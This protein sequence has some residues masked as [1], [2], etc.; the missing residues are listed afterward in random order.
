MRVSATPERRTELLEKLL[1]VTARLAE[2]PDPIKLMERILDEGIAIVR[3]ERGF[4]VA[5]FRAADG[6]LTFRVVAA[7]NVEKAA[8]EKPDF[9]FSRTVVRKVA[10]AG[11]AQLVTDAP[12]DPLTKDVTSI[13]VIDVR[14]VICAPL[15]AQGQTLGVLYLDHR[16]VKR[17]FTAGDLAAVETFARPAAV[18]LAAAQR[19]EQIAAQRDEL[20]KRV[21]IIERLR[22][23]LKEQYL[24]RSRELNQLREQAPAAPGSE[25]GVPEIVA[26]SPAMKAV[27]QLVRRVAPADASVLIVG[28]SGTGKEGLARA[29]HSRSPRARGPFRAE[30]CAAIPDTLLESELFGHER[31]AFTGAE[32]ARVGIF[33][34]ARGGTILLDEIGDMSPSLQVKLLRVLQERAIRRVGGDELIPVDVRIIGATHHDLEAMVA[35]GRFRADL[36]YRLNVVRIEVPP[37]RERLA[38]IPALIDHFLA[39]FRDQNLVVEPQVRELLLTYP[40]PGNVRELQN[41]VRRLAVLAGQGGTVR[42]GLL[43]ASILAHAGRG[44]REANKGAAAEPLLPAMWR[45]DDV[46][47][48]AIL[49]A[50]RH[51][52]G[53]KTS[54]AKLLGVPKTTLYHRMEK[55]EI[56]S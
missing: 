53:N 45:L 50:L 37:L 24:E 38:C 21:A 47:R 40:W 5:S 8:I 46:E 35:D 54:A 44:P 15:R 33:E 29:L 32:S 25:P 26:R 43:S 12:N 55:L 20:A 36:Y 30:N 9:E 51:C 1:E 27:L 39:A 34:A 16:F 4:A 41:E 22:A 31:G 7:R 28:E 49:R 11:V 2:E 6:N 13:N 18:V 23:E 48:E 52:H 10:E 3:A 14:S 42:P 56:E 17:E 19:A